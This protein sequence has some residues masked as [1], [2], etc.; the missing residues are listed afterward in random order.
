[1]RELVEQMLSSSVRRLEHPAAVDRCKP[2]GLPPVLPIK[3]EAGARGL[4]F[5]TMR[6]IVWVNR[7][8]EARLSPG[9]ADPG[10]GWERV[11]S[12]DSVTEKNLVVQVQACMGVRATRPAATDFFLSGDPAVGW[13]ATAND[14]DGPFALAIDPVGDG[15]YL[16]AARPARIRSF[17]RRAPEPSP[18]L[19]V[20]P[21]IIP[22]HL[23]KGP[24]CLFNRPVG[25]S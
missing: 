6:L 10:V 1:M 3:S 18:A 5:G 7:D 19:I 16:R 22:I 25:A 21:V 11:G 4:R 9:P 20:R 15:K 17:A 13:V 14:L 12:A 8:P 24:E 2:A 23:S